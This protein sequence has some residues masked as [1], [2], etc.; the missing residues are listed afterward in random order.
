MNLIPRPALALFLLALGA[1]V[2]QAV[3]L[4][5][6]GQT[7]CYDVAGAT[8]TCT[9]VN[10]ANRDD[11]RYGRD[12]TSVAGALTKTGAGAAGFDY[13]K[14]ANDGSTL[15][16]G[17]A[18]GGNPIDWACTKDN[19]TG[20]TWEV[21]TTGASDLRKSTHTYTWYSTDAASNGGNAGNT[22]S[23][24]C[25]A[26]LPG[27]QCNT[28]AYVAAVNAATLCGNNDWRLPSVKELESLVNFSV[29]ATGAAPTIE[30]TYFPNTAINWY[31]TATNNSAVPANVW[32]VYF[33]GGNSNA[34]LKS[35]FNYVRLV[36]GGQ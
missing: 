20:L 24:T 29:P 10:P 4:P 33:Y 19:T 14:I 36:R 1:P 15:A 21:K 18:L 25:A 27:N 12:P 17:T 22:G 11:G 35:D 3:G 5:D 6:T 7:L 30:A 31:W 9:T 16:A 28:Q 13:S 8:V 32:V 23:N 34:Y 2:A 26:T